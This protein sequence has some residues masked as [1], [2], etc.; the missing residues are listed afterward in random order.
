M[1][2]WGHDADFTSAKDIAIFAQRASLDMFSTLGV[3]SSKTVHSPIT[4]WLTNTVSISKGSSHYLVSNISMSSYQTKLTMIAIEYL[5]GSGVNG[6]M[7]TLGNFCNTDGHVPHIS[8]WYKIV[9]TL[10]QL[11]VFIALMVITLALTNNNDTLF[12][13]T[14][15]L[16]RYISNDKLKP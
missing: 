3:V 4:E 15:T 6:S 11:I 5:K 8:R 13:D 16:L 9:F 14:P 7:T 2:D 1:Y 12:N 10:V